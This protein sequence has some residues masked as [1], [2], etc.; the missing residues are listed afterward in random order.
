MDLSRHGGNSA[1]QDEAGRGRGRQK[2]TTSRGIWRGKCSMEPCGPCFCGVQY[3][4][5]DETR[6]T[7]TAAAARGEAASTGLAH[8]KGLGLGPV[9]PLVVGKPQRDGKARQTS[10]GRP[11]RRK[12]RKR[13][14]SCRARAQG[15]VFW[16]RRGGKT[17]CSGVGRPSNERRREERLSGRG[18][19]GDP[20]QEGFGHKG[21]L[22]W[23]GGAG[24]QVGTSGTWLAACC[25]VAVGIQNK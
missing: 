24:L 25:W 17:A 22:R 8:Q 2:Q 12:E 1:K 4:V 14:S 13:Q 23:R 11:D 6:C 10:L 5:R 15:L 20:D 16:S 3:N 7:A 21:P 9:G 19:P 18:Q